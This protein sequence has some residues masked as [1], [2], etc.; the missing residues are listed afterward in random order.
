MLARNAAATALAIGALAA[1]VD[2]GPDRP[3]GRTSLFMPDTGEGGETTDG[4]AV[5]GDDGGGARADAG[6]AGLAD[7]GARDAAS[8]RDAAPARDAFPGS[9]GDPAS[10]TR[11]EVCAAYRAGQVE[12]AVNGGFSKTEAMCDPGVVSPEGIA[13]AMRRLDFHR[14][15]AGIGPAAEGPSS[16]AAAQ[17]CALISAWNPAGQQAH[18]PSPDATCYTREGAGAAGASN[19]AWGN[20]TAANAI[21]QWIVDRGNETTFGHR[22]WL[23]NPPLSNVGIGAY[24]G[25]NNY[26]SASCITVFGSGGSSTG[27]AVIVY[28][29]PGFVPEDIAE[30]PWTLQGRVPQR[31]LAVTVT[32][33]STGASQQ[34]G[35]EALNGGYG[36]SPG[37]RIIRAWRVARDETYDVEVTGDGSPPITYA[38]TPIDCP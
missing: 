17:D 36:G 4:G 2:T 13:D 24:Q 12:D 22:R 16:H 27:P 21:D 18:Q 1:C 6:P 33:R 37:L 34:V 11:A 29:P 9:P 15:L 26:G 25:G 8:G 38:I 7:A 31:D 10:R 3:A 20:R 5:A 35:V 32:A 14:W 23:L 28:P 19:I 30:W